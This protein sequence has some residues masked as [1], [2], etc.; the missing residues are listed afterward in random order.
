MTFAELS[1]Y[2]EKLEAT[3]SRLALIDIL[4]DLF[5]HSGKDEID[6][7]VYLTQARVAPF[8]EPIEIGMAEKHVAS[9]I[10]SAYSS[11]KEEVLKL[12]GKLGDMG[13]VAQELNNRHSGNPAMRGHP[14][15]W[16]GFWT[17]PSTA[18]S[19]QSSCQNDGK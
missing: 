18:S 12:Y 19:G 8:F 6:K 1:K 16:R 11:T 15:S 9:S 10:A 5:K 7:I 4:S 13:L 14:E 3:A 17:S 2:F